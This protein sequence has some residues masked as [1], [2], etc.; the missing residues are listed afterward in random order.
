MSNKHLGFH[1]KEVEEEEKQIKDRERA[2]EK[3][4]KGRWL[5]W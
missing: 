3:Y 2:G 4:V 5:S 1:F